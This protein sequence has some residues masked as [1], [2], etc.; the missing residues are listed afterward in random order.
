VLRVV[1][2]LSHIV[3]NAAGTDSTARGYVVTC[4]DEILWELILL[5]RYESIES[6]FINRMLP[7]LLRIKAAP[8]L[9]QDPIR[10]F[11]E[12]SIC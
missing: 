10:R 2:C 8:E 6:E 5:L 11:F 12:N 4:Q 9:L 1:I 7:M 3:R